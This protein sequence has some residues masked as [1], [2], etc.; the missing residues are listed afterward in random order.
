MVEVNTGLRDEKRASD[1]LNYG[2]T[3]VKLSCEQYICI[4]ILLNIPLIFTDVELV[5]YMLA[6]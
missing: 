1:G 2:R 6:Y 4:C 5:I 3:S